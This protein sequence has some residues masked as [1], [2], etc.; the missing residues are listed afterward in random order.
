MRNIYGINYKDLAQKYGLSYNGV[1]NLCK[2][3]N[4]KSEEEAIKA[5]ED[6]EA[7]IPHIGDKFG[8]LTIISNETKLIGTHKKV[9][10]KCDCGKIEWR[11]WTDLRYG[12]STQCKECRNKSYMIPIKIGEKF[13]KLTVI[14]GPIYG[15]QKNH[16][17]YKCQCACGNICYNTS[18]DLTTGKATQCHHCG[19]KQGG[20]TRIINN[21]GVG[22]LQIMKINSI[23]IGAKKRNLEYNLT[24]QYLWNLYLQQNKRCALTGDYMS[25]IMRASLDR[26]DSSKGYIEGNVQWTTI[27]ANIAKQ[28]MKESDF[29]ELCQKVVNHANQQPS[30]PLTKQ[31]GSE[32]KN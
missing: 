24:P 11:T 16:L 3:H 8:K 23:K 32:T 20:K 18:T 22:D 17:V 12:R 5:L 30:L 14:D 7:K 25:N 6:R 21:G 31:E 2:R 9:L 26:I 1:L 27:D 10:T 28:D 13:G 19:L 29:I 15:R 4:I